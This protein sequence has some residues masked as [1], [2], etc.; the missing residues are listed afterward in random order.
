MLNLLAL[1]PSALSYYLRRK[2][3]PRLIGK[4]SNAPL[5]VG[6]GFIALLAGLVSLEYFGIINIVPRFGVDSHRADTYQTPA[7]P[8]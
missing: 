1:V 6:L 7:L 8:Q 4:R 2:S 3:M 5:Y